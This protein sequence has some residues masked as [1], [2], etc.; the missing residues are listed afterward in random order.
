MRTFFEFF[1]VLVTVIFFSNAYYRCIVFHIYIQNLSE[2]MSAYDTSW[3]HSLHH[4]QKEKK[5][6]RSKRDI[7]IL[8]ETD[9][10]RLKRERDERLCNSIFTKIRS[11]IRNRRCLYGVIIASPTD[12]FRLLDGDMDGELSVRDL[13]VGLKR[14]GLGL[15]EDQIRRV[16]HVRLLERTNEKLFSTP[17]SQTIHSNDPLK[18]S[19][20]EKYR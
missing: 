18:R 14:L 12:A 6:I 10:S 20:P 15:K 16:V 19:T 9:P 8:K 11:A 4:Q 5:K 13:F 3:I 7:S 2:T 1:L 17:A